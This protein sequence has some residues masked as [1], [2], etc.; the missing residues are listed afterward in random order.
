[1]KALETLKDLL[2][3]EVKMCERLSQETEILN[4]DPSSSLM[5][6]FGLGQGAW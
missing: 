1:M 5:L 3:A 6:A 4:V 2:V